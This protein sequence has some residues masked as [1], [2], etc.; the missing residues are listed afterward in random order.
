V[1]ANADRRG[2]IKIDRNANSQELETAYRS[3]RV[4]V[5]I[6]KEWESEWDLSA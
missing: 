1:L 4:E 5:V 6:F 2:I 3:R